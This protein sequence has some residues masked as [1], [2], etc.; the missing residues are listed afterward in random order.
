MGCDGLAEA[1]PKGVTEP[2]DLGAGLVWQGGHGAVPVLTGL[3][4]IGAGLAG[5]EKEQS[6]SRSL[7]QCSA[8]CARCGFVL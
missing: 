4:H 6:W 3:Q 2:A 1:T 5:P 8:R 7:V